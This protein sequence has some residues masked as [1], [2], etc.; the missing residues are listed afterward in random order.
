MYA[1]PVVY[2]IQLIPE[3]WRPLYSL[4]P[5]VGV[6]EGFRWALLGTPQPDVVAMAV[7]TTV[8]LLLLVGGTVYFKRM[9]R[10]FADI[11]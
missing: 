10:T 1:S 3:P 11:I 6:I 5:M 7:S 8:V 2:S 4:N 9:E